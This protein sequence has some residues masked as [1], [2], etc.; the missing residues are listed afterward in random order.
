ML[1]ISDYRW[2]LVVARKASPVI[3]RKSKCGLSVFAAHYQKMPYST[4]SWNSGL[5]RM[6]N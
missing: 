1:P 3:E 6:R 4:V 5:Q 2:H